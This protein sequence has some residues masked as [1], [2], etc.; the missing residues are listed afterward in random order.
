VDREQRPAQRRGVGQR[1]HADPVDRKRL[2]ALQEHGHA[3]ATA[4]RVLDFSDRD[5]VLRERP[6]ARSIG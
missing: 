5:V 2:I 4:D 3:R 1:A 6:V